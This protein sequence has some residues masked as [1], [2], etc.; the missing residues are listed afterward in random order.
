MQGNIC[1]VC[2]ASDAERIVIAFLGMLRAEG[3]ERLKMLQMG[4]S[5]VTE[6]YCMGRN[7]FGEEFYTQYGFD[8]S[9]VLYVAARKTTWFS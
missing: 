4:D 6:C 2:K 9:A 1:P 3:E 5:A 7:W 8:E